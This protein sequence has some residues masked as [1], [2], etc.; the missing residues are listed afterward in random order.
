MLPKERW[1]TPPILSG[2]GRGLINRFE[3]LKEAQ[4]RALERGIHASSLPREP[5]GESFLQMRQSRAVVEVAALA[6]GFGLCWI[7]INHGDEFS[8]TKFRR[9]CKCWASF[10][11]GIMTEITL[12]ICIGSA[13][14]PRSL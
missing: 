1:H 13:V 4:A 2:I 3:E 9:H 11:V 14:F 8:Q 7:G 10:N 12:S 5:A 6:N